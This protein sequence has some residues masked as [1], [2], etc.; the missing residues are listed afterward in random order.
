[1]SLREQTIPDE[2][3]YQFTGPG[4]VYLELI[5]PSRNSRRAYWLELRQD[6]VGYIIRRSWGRIGRD[7]KDLEHRHTCLAAALKEANS[8][9]REKLRKGYKQKERPWSQGCLYFQEGVNNRG[10]TEQTAAKG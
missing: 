9:C 6:N 10:L 7:P 3:S 2:A 4:Q 1:M 8:K 5:D